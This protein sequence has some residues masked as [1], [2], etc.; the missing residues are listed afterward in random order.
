MTPTGLFIGALFVAA[1]V[2]E[3][4]VAAAGESR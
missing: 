2:R 1:L 3:R 4:N